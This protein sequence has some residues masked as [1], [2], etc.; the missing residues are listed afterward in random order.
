MMPD[1]VFIDTWGWLA[2]GHRKDLFHKEVMEYYQ[3]LR[4]GNSL[5]FTSD[6][7]L[8]ETITLLFRREKYEEA[9]KFMGG[10]FQAIESGYITVDRITSQRF[11]SAWESRKKFKDKPLISFTDI[12]TMVIMRERGIKYILTKDEHFTHVGMDLQ[13]VF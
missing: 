8:D 13:T 11:L 9:V 3:K 12:T 6:Y 2:I 4:A 5:I 1:K 10:I 7:V